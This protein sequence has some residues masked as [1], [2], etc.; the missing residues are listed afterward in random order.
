MTDGAHDDAPFLETLRRRAAARPRRIVLPESGDPRVIRAAA[1]AARDRL[2]HPVLLGEPEVVRAR[3]SEVGAPEPDALTVVDP[4]DPDR[5]AS[6]AEMLAEARRRRGGSASPLPLAP[7]ASITQAA[8]M[9]ASGEVDGGVAG[10]ELTTATVV[11]AALRLVGT[12]EP[13]ASLSSAF[14]MVFGSSHPLGARVLTFT[15]AGVLPEPDEEQLAR[16]A[17][18]A[19]RAHGGVVGEEPRVA[20]LSY[21]TK[22]SA[23]GRTVSL[24]RRALARFRELAPDLSAD[25]ELQGDA[26]LVSEVAAR[27][28]PG[29]EVAGRANVLVFP[30]LAAAN[31]GY[32]LVQHLGGA[33]ALGP[34]LQGL[35][36]PFNDLSRGCTADDI[37]AVGCI[38][39]LM[40]DGAGQPRSFPDARP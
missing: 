14:L 20:F 19:A 1:S 31:I 6:C 13:G 15:D 18:A 37:V 4:T 23:E 22:G 30:D 16:A 27:K 2:F 35:A 40:A 7:E 38:A 9:V 39:S 28:A 29:S 36:R 24:A 25:G 10:S 33:Q 8:A 12:A 21:S 3:L 5:I 26:A 32:K 11:R 17:V 34:V